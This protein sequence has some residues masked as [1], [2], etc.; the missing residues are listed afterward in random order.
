MIREI[1]R[2]EILENIQSLRFVLSL[3]LIVSIFITSGVAFVN[4]YRQE[5]TDFRSETNKNFS[6]LS[7]RAK[8]LSQLAHYKQT[9]WRK[10]KV[11]TLCAEGFE[12]SLPNRFKVNVFRIDYPEVKSRSNFMLLRFSDIDWVFIVSFILSFVALLLT[13]DSICGEKEAATLALMLSGPTPRDKVL[14]GKYLAAML[15]LG[16]PLLLGM[17]ANFIIVSFSDVV[18]IGAGEWLKIFAI[19]LLAFLYLSLF[20]LL[21]M[22]VSSRTARSSTSM[23]ILLLLWVGLVILIPS[24]GRIVSDKFHRIPNRA[25]VDRRITEARAQIWE[26]PDKYGKNAGNWGGRFRRR[27]GQS[28][29]ESPAEKCDHQRPKSDLRRIRQRDDGAGEHGTPLHLYLTDCALSACV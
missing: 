29:G 16:I 9:I 19:V 4:K 25:E 26:N 8:N 20:V 28:P 1:I 7:E 11:L 27:L 15:T 21:G 14:L 13:Y 2:K 24:F 12:K 6:A 17:L 10:P 3:L 5:V 22:F 18:V 23:V